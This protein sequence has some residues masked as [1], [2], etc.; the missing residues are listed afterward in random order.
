MTWTVAGLVLS[1]AVAAFAWYRSR[2]RGGFYDAHVYGMTAAMHR[3]YALISLAFA[4]Y[5]ACALA[6]RWETPVMVGLTLY[7]L[8]A[9]F[10]ATS[11]LR[12]FSDD[13]GG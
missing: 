4:V 5:F 7:V 6:W 9:I 12:G 13:D 10:Y 1:L 8:V 3:R 2:V 11:F